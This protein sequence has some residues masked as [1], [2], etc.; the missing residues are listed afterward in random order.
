M[1]SEEHMPELPVNHDALQPL[2]E[3]NNTVG[4]VGFLGLSREMENTFVD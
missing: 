2:S 1:A 3:A 4:I